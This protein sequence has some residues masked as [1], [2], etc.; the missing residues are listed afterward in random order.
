MKSLTHGALDN[1]RTSATTRMLVFACY[2]G[3]NQIIK[4]LSFHLELNGVLTKKSLFTCKLNRTCALDE[5]CVFCLRCFHGTNHEGHDT[6]FSVN[7]GGGGCCDC[8]DPEA[9]KVELDCIYHSAKHIPQG[10]T[11]PKNLEYPPEVTTSI[12]RTIAAVLDF[13]IDTMTTSPENMNGTRVSKE[14][15]QRDAVDA[16]NIAGETTNLDLMDFVCILWNDE[17]HSFTDVIN[18][19]SET[20]H[21]ASNYARKIAETVDTQVS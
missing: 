7:N 13:I 15:I 12:R 5:T 21:M 16:G 2:C 20:T 10:E 8:G 1:I 3:A 19:V 17:D 14:Q 11:D 4:T 6:S 18:R 9:W